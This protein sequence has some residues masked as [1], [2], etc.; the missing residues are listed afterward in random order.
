MSQDTSNPLPD[1]QNVPPQPPA[2]APPLA[3]VK[4]KRRRWPWVIGAVVL[5]L[6]VLVLIAPTLIS[7]GFARAIV[8]SQVNGKLNA[9]VQ[10]KDWSLGWFSPISLDGVVVNDASNRQILQLS[11]VSTGLNLWNALRGKYELGQTKIEGLDVLVSREADGSIN[12]QHIAKGSET[13]SKT[14]GGNEGAGAGGKSNTTAKLPDV[15]GQVI[16]SDASLTYEDRSHNSPPVQLRGVQLDV[17]IADINQPISDTLAAQVQVGSAPPGTIAAGGTIKAVANNEVSQNTADVDQTVKLSGLELSALSGLLGPSAPAQLKG[18]TDGQLVIHLAN[19]KDGTVQASLDSK[20]FGASGG[21]MADA[22]V[23]TD[24]LTFRIP[25]TTFQ[26]PQGAD[27]AS[28]N[29]KLQLGD[30]VS[31][32]LANVNIVQGQGATARKVLTGDTLNF[33]AQGGY[34]ADGGRKNVQLTKLALSDTQ[35]LVS[36]KKSVDSDFSLLLPVSGNPTARGSIE[37]A[38]DLKRLNEVAQAMSA[39]HVAA[40]DPTGMELQSG[41]LAGRLALAQANNELISITGDLGVTQI[42]VGNASSAPIKDEKI[43]IA[44]KAS[45]NHDLSDIEPEVHFSGDLLSGAITDT[46]L[47]LAGSSS[48][49]QKLKKTTLSLEIPS[50]PKVQ[51]LLR[52][53]SPPKTARIE[54]GTALAYAGKTPPAGSAPPAKQ[55]ESPP[56]DITSGSA[57]ITIKADPVGQ[58]LHLSPQVTVSNL[59]LK[60]GESTYAL[61]TATVTADA[62]ASPTADS[63]GIAEV[64]VKSS[65]ID[66]NNLAIKG[67]PYPEKQLHVSS[68]LSLQPTAHVLD[69]RNLTLQTADTKAVTAV[70]KGRITELGSGQKIDNALTLDLDYDAAQLLNLTKPLLSADLQD[71]LKDA[72]AAGKYHKQFAFRGAYSYGM[73]FG[74]AIQQLRGGGDMDVDSFDGAGLSLKNFHLPFTLVAGFLRLTYP[75]KPTGQNVPPPAAL[76]GG[77]LNLGGS[78]VDLRGATPRL[79]TLDNL[80]VLQNVSLNPVFASWSLGTFLDNPMFVSPKNT[81]G[82]LSITIENCRDLPLDSSLTKSSTGSATLNASVQ[83]LQV[84]NDF[85]GKLASVARFDPNSIRGDIRTW[86]III[87]N[88]IVQQDMTMTFLQGQRPLKLF[89]KVRMADKML[90]PLTLD[91]PWK[92]FGI[93]GVP[94]EAQKF[95]PEGVEIPLTGTLDNP[96]FSFNFDQLVQNAV[97]QQFLGPGILG[98]KNDQNTTQPSEQPDPIKAIQDLLNKNK[99]K[100]N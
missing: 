20:G 21:K 35:G 90:M 48:A 32:Q 8:V 16:V 81:A 25:H 73:E 63:N 65:A 26:L 94:P 56:T 33:E 86:T 36:V 60:Q 43:Q 34:G 66:L 13:G 95:L 19:G 88:G 70:L 23:A 45:A 80:P 42:T 69:L 9:H 11:R 17:N 57:T 5:M 44:L 10:I 2:A 12:W 61:S 30:G 78:Q 18:R 27:Q 99:K 62:T 22:I 15:R 1:P 67:Q 84:S 77:T 49:L 4:K 97:K 31:L 82:I 91:L 52:S 59:G 89:G 47:S 7:L 14:S 68:E 3:P 96:Q 28:Q 24:S 58:G 54:H 72:T 83:Q 29:I 46:K 74:K 76:N 100:K 87:S 37:L 64:N 71:K 40:K 39:P 93:K 6:I 98:G 53:F 55:A 51:A 85:L 75:D 38:A 92:L 79:T 50:L 41:K